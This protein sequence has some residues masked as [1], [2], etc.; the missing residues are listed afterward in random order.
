VKWSFLPDQ[1]DF[2]NFKPYREGPDGY[3]GALSID[4]IGCMVH[5]KEKESVF[6]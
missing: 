3:Y 5:L 4:G 2:V 1:V 6:G